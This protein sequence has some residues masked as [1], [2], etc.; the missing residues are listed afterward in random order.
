MRG[1]K[2]YCNIAIKI[3]RDFQTFG[4]LFGGIIDKG[5]TAE[6]AVRREAKEE[7][8]ID[9]GELQFCGKYL[10]RK[11]ELNLYV[12]RPDIPVEQLKKQQ[13]EGDDLGMFS[14]DELGLLEM[15]PAIK[16]IIQKN[17]KSSI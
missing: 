11:Y 8:G 15:L 10:L 9:L 14:F 7:I 5:E 17:F 2:Y 16:K 13:A 4:G 1:G 3:W 6:I 12:G